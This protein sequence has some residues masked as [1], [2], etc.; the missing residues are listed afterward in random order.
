MTRRGLHG[1]RTMSSKKRRAR[2]DAL[3]QIQNGHCAKC[4]V[5]YEKH[6]LILKR[7]L[8]RMAGGG[9]EPSNLHLI[10]HTCN[11]GQRHH[12]Q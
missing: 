5:Q 12:T 1:T 7:I 10:C 4:G 11:P 8:H 2:K 3:Y 9:D 6:E